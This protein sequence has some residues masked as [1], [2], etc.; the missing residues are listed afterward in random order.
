[1]FLLILLDEFKGRFHADILASMQNNIFLNKVDNFDVK[2]RP[3]HL[4]H[5]I[6]K[7]AVL[8]PSNGQISVILDKIPIFFFQK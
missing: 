8:P 1:M 3:D 7:M 2:I 6:V 5:N 4:P